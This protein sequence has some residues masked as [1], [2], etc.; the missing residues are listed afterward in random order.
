M[1]ATRTPLAP[2]K[3]APDLLDQYYL[4]IRCHLLEA[5][6]AFDRLDRARDA[7]AAKKDPRLQKLR[8]ALEI[9][10][11]DG[12]DRAQRFLEMFSEPCA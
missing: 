7:D 2:P 6:A 1:P 8:A 5:A 3:S 11:S 12:S 4:E 10:A 9:L